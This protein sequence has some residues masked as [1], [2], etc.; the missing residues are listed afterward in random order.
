MHNL[1][2]ATVIFNI[3]SLFGFVSADILSRKCKN[4]DVVA[5]YVT[6][7]SV[8][9]IFY[10]LALVVL[11]GYK[12][13]HGLYTDSLITIFFIGSPFIIGNIATYKKATVYINLQ[14]FLLAL[15][16]FCVIRHI[17]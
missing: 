12:L 15:S 6:M 16:L 5:A 14:A 9:F 4:P 7:L 8:V 1:F 17:I 3:L 2:L 13:I 11:L 10:L